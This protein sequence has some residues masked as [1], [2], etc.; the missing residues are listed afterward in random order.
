MMTRKECKMIAEELMGLFVKHGM[1]PTMLAPERYMNVREAAAYLSMPVSTLY[2]KVD[3]IPHVKK[4]R[5]LVFAESALREY[6]EGY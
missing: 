4:G 1:K 2:K 3:E 6:V 5:R